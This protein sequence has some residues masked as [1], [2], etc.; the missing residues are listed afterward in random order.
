MA[1][2]PMWT[3]G[4][5]TK[6]DPLSLR[7]IPAK[8]GVYVFI[9]N[10]EVV[11]VGQTA[12]LRLRI[13]NHKIRYGYARNVYTPWGQYHD[14]SKIVCKV[15]ISKRYGDWAMWELRLIKRLRPTF[16]IRSTRAVA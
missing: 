4:R 13:A 6:F 8:P 11:Y 14:W 16:N 1:E 7:P 15:K 9:I 12:N 3:P 2:F 5:W 10:G